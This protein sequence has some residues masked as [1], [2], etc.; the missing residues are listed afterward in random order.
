[1]F[2][3]LR[4]LESLRIAAPQHEESGSGREVVFVGGAAG[5]DFAPVASGLVS[6]LVER[7]PVLRAS[8]IVA[9]DRAK[10]KRARVAV[11]ELTVELMAAAERDGAL[12]NDAL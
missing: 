8:R 12:A 9:G 3:G 1:V 11:V 7:E 5:E 6:G 10:P 2:A 4:Q